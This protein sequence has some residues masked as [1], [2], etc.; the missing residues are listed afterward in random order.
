MHT[1]ACVGIDMNT[2]VKH[3]P[4]WPLHSSVQAMS[5]LE[6]AFNK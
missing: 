1:L 2:K 5:I 4:I 3:I 6:S